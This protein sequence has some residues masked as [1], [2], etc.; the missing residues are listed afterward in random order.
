MQPLLRASDP[1]ARLIIVHNRLAQNRLADLLERR[2][3]ST[4]GLVDVV[5]N[6][7]RAYRQPEQI[8]QGLRCPVDRHVLYCVK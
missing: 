3:L 7:A 8:S 6:G 1:H 5:L 2:W 4:G